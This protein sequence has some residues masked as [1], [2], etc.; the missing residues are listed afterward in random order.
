MS[1][2]TVFL[3]NKNIIFKTIRSKVTDYAALIRGM[4]YSVTLINIPKTKSNSTLSTTE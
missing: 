2:L 1:I 3:K 4:H